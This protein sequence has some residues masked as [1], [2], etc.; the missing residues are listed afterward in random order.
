MSKAKKYLYAAFMYQQAIEKILKT[1][2]YGIDKIL[3]QIL[4]SSW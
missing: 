1:P 3:K 4:D 2:F